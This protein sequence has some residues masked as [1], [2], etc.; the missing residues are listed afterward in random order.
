MK[1]FEA[2]YPHI[3]PSFHPLSPSHFEQHEAIFQD[4]FLLIGAPKIID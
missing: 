4:I 2:P 3:D 1:S